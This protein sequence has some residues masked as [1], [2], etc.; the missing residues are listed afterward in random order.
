MDFPVPRARPRRCTGA[1]SRARN[2]N[3]QVRDAERFFATVLQR[4]NNERN[5]RRSTAGA[6]SSHGRAGSVSP[7]R[8]A[9][10]RSRHIGEQGDCRAQ[11]RGKWAADFGA[12]G[13][14]P[15]PPLCAGHCSTSRPPHQYGQLFL[16]NDEHSNPRGRHCM[17]VRR[18]RQHCCVCSPP[19]QPCSKG[20]HRDCNGKANTRTSA[21]STPHSGVPLSYRLGTH[22]L[23]TCCS[24]R[25]RMCRTRK[26][27]LRLWGYLIN[28]E[29]QIHSK[30]GRRLPGSRALR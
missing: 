28:A 12:V 8:E 24:Y 26:T 17:L 10:R 3:V 16:H 15:R 19:P 20:T 7:N 13:P 11:T 21:S 30:V 29:P 1:L 23:Y 27:K 6:L 5:H 14:R 18:H 9:T 2:S 4:Q 25:C 22:G